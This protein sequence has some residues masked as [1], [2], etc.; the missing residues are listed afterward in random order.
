M[1]INVAAL[2]YDAIVLGCD[3]F[4]SL[5]DT[6]VFPL[7]PEGFVAPFAQPYIQTVATTVFGGIVVVN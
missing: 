7:R 3:S 5:T 2:T 6:A 1:T 4:S